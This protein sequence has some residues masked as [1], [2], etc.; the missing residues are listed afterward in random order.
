MRPRA[1]FLL[2]APAVWLYGYV[3]RPDA[4]AE[5]FEFLL[6]PDETANTISMPRLLV[7]CGVVTSQYAGVGMLAAGGGGHGRR[8]T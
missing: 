4:A 7:Y 1:Y 8:I 5:G 6:R 3:R 2:R